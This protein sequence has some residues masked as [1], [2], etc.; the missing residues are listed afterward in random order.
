MSLNKFPELQKTERPANIYEVDP[1]GDPRWKAFIAAHPRSSVFHT[2]EWLQALSRTYGYEPVVA[3]TSPL[4]EPI[5]SGI[6][7]CRIKSWLTGSRIVSLPFSDHCQPLVDNEDAAGALLDSMCA[8]VIAEG[9]RYCE[10]RPRSI[11][12]ITPDVDFPMAESETCCFHVLDLRPS[13]DDIHH[14]FHNTRIRQMI[15][16]GE[17]EGLS[18][19][20]GRSDAHLKMFYALMLVTRRRHQLPPQPMRWFRNLI[21]C[22]GETLRI[23][24]SL[25]GDLPVAAVLTLSWQK[26]V[27]LKYIC[28]DA[29]FHNLGALQLLI[30]HVIRNAKERGADELDFGRSDSDNE[31]LIKFKE[32]WGCQRSTLTYYRYPAKGNPTKSRQARSLAKLFAVLPDFWLTAAGRV[33]YRHI[34]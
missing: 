25:K 15:R 8:R 18:I 19:S 1:L 10:I 13:T 7:C 14:R 5:S 17:R 20:E 12:R 31:G 34:G 28:S 33:L 9:A 11:A 30:W 32:S 27:M 6:V 21:D 23:H 16:R 3:T 29:R 26:T 22:L 2:P 24:I 4:G